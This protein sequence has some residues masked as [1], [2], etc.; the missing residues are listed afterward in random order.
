MKFIIQDLSKT[1]GSAPQPIHGDPQVASRITF[2]EHDFFKEQPLKGADGQC[3]RLSTPR[4]TGAEQ[5]SVVLTP[6]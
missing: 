2:Q 1:I 5:T 6:R 3:Y 4:R